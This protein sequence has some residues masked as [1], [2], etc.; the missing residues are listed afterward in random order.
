MIQVLRTLSHRERLRRLNLNSL[1]RRRVK[2]DLIEVYNWMQGYNKG[3]IN[4]VLIAR[5]QDTT[6]SNGFKLDKFRFKRDI[7]KNWFTKRVLNEWNRLISHG[8]SANTEDTFKKSLDK[9]MDGEGRW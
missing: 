6:R 4:K 1:E 3:D 7:G 2:G 5:E 8:G 9:F